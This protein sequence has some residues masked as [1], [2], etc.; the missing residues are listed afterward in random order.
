VKDPIGVILAGGRGRRIGGSKA[1]VSLCGRP[2]ISYPLEALQRALTD[3]AILAKP[4]SELPPLPGVTV[5]REPEREH[6]PLIGIVSALE[7]AGGRPVLVCAADMPFVTPRLVRRL[8]TVD[9]LA[10]A[11]WRGAMQ[12]L[13]GRYDASAGE[14][15]KG[16]LG[17]LREAISELRP[18]VVEV[19]DPRALFNVNSS[20]DLLQATEMLKRER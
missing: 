12:P 16:Q 8:A 4:H 11:A 20:A 3:V 7:L 10:V 5:W 13:V 14:R 15:L 19:E 18:Q 2:L 6:H 9:G 17:P 1:A